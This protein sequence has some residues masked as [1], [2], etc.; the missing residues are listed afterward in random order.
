MKIAQTYRNAFAQML[1]DD[2]AGGKIRYYSDPMPATPETALSGQTLIAELT[3]ANPAGTVT[4]GA[5][6]FNP[7]NEDNSADATGA[8]TWARFLKADGSTVVLDA[9]VGV[10]LDL[11]GDGGTTAGQQVVIDG[12]VLTVGGGA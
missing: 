5:L 2:L 12:L 9:T 11:D 10:G 8:A 3:C 4:G 6:V 7:I 1:C